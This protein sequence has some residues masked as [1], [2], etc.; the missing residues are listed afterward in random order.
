MFRT[1]EVGHKVDKETFEREEPALHARLLQAQRALAASGRQVIIIVAG[2]EAAGKSEVVNRLNEWLDA[3]GLSTSAF[4]EESDEERE[5]PRHWRFWRSM[6]PRG[7]IGI[8]FGSWYTQP[9]VERAHG[10]SQPAEFEAELVRINGLERMLTDDGALIVKLWFHLSRKAQDQRL[11]SIARENKRQLTP[12]EKAYA[13]MYEAFA[14]VSEG[15]ITRTDTAHAPWHIIESADGRYRD[16]TAGRKVLAALEDGLAKRPAASAPRATPALPAERVTVLDRIDLSGRMERA[17]YERRM[18]EAQSRLNALVWK[19]RE[20]KRSVVAMFEGWDAAGKGGAIRRITQAL[21]A[22]LFRVIPVAAPTDEER[23]QHHLWRFW[24]HV[25]RGGYVTLYDRSWYGRVLVER[26]EGFAAHDEWAR[27]YQEINDFERQLT[28][29]G[30]VLAKFWLHISPAE[31]LRRF[32]ERQRIEHKRHK[33]TD[34]DWR[35]REKWPDYEAAVEEMVAR[36][37]PPQAPWSLVAADCKLSARV[38]VVQT[39]ADR[40]ELALD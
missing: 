12:W 33:I 22:R 17:T 18:R 32:E 16:L 20:R 24:R 30:T 1:A 38:N 21:D 3:R 28:E 11:K 2:V 40:I 29:H 7:S 19:A 9:I 26:V 25:P 10:R 13:S 14:E 34:E 39:L 36:C 5:R 27:A 37:S 4:W 8:L 35:N 31:Q 23:A 15:A 6:P